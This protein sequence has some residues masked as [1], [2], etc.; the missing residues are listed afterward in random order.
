MKACLRRNERW[1]EEQ[2]DKGGAPLM[3]PAQRILGPARKAEQRRAARRINASSPPD[4]IPQEIEKSSNI[5]L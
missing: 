3:V 4:G 2:G 5:S 1:Q